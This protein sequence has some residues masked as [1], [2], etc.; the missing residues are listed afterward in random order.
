MITQSK[1]QARLAKPQ[2]RLVLPELLAHRGNAAEF[3]ENSLP[4]LRSALDLGVRHVQFDVQLSADRQPML[5][6]DANLRRTAGI[7]C[8][9]LQMTSQELAGVVA[10]ETQRFQDRFTDVGIPTLT[11]A[12]GIL[13]AHPAVTAFV[14]LERASLRAFGHEVVVHKVCEALHPVA[15]Q[16]VITSY[17]LHAV[18]LVRQMSSYRMGW[19]LSEYTALSALKCEALAPDFVICDHQLL[20]EH[21]A[22]LWRGGWRWIVYDVVSRQQALQL[23][24]RGAYL[25]GTTEVRRLQ[26][27]F[28]GLRELS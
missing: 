15:R 18:H 5:L 25:V 7:D 6:H 11:Q 1:P 21:G 8:D 9:A 17:D 10:N 4:A 22:R 19:V 2:A 16:C 13:Q 3:P 28:R 24:A 14:Q 23:A 27:E 12:V 26:R 20:T